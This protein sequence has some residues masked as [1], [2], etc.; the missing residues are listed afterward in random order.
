[1]TTLS[2]NNIPVELRTH[3]QWCTF[4]FEKRDDSDTKLTKIPYN[5]EKNYR[6]ATTKEEQ[7]CWYDDC[8]R[9]VDKGKYDG[10]GFIFANRLCGH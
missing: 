9:A 4:K 7:W 5:V 10:I 1:M 6:L 8:K 3:K 2:Y